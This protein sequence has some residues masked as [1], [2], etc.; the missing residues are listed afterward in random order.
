METI[1]IIRDARFTKSGRRFLLTRRWVADEATPFVLFCMLNPSTANATTDD[2]TI[3]K[4]MAF[5]RSWGYGALRV[6]NLYDYVTASPKEL[7]VWA[8]KYEA[9][10]ARRHHEEHALDLI[11]I[12]SETADLTVCAWGAFGKEFA[13][14]ARV[15]YP[16]L[17]RPHALRVTKDG[18]PGHPLYLPGNLVPVPYSLPNA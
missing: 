7:K 1:P 5:A 4:C 9:I 2:P 16:Y 13:A 10:N 18:H 14:R 11:G 6:V 12:Q 8:E 3:R 15:V 17:S